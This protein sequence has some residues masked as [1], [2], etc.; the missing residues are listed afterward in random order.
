V[1]VAVGDI[2]EYQVSS[3]DPDVEFPLKR[4]E[5]AA[6][7]PESY[8][9]RLNRG[10][11]RKTRVDR[12]PEL[13]DFYNENDPFAVTNKDRNEFKDF[14]EKLRD[15]ERPVLDRAIKSGE[16]V[17][18]VDFKNVGGLVTPL[19]LTLTYADGSSEE[20]SIPAE[21]WRY[22]AL[23]VTKLFVRKK[24][25]VSV[26]LD[27]NHLIADADKTNNITPRRIEQS[28]IELFRGRD[29]DRNQMLDALA[30]LKG[31]PKADTA[32]GA[33]GGKDIPLQ[34]VAK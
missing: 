24:R 9:Q 25:L 6:D 5:F 28:R 32:N 3:Q 14:R 22:N 33:A 1:D 34:P 30:E 16:Y 15:W 17:Y 26:E 10:E 19:P 29:R 21:V 27:R 12:Y 13:K 8:S 18:F 23:E 7:W 31:E 11:G 20:Y 4:K 2:R